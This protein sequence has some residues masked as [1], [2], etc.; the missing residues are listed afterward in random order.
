MKIRNA[1]AEDASRIAEI[2]VWAW[3]KAYDGLF[4]VELLEGLSVAD[5]TS[6]WRER[7]RSGKV[8]MIVAEI[9]GEVA[10]DH[11]AARRTPVPD[12]ISHTTPIYSADVSL[13]MANCQA[14]PR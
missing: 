2:H 12:W 14:P 6:T 7:L 9:Q 1:N 5:R 11:A 8:P 10:T 4:P 3:Q 13:D